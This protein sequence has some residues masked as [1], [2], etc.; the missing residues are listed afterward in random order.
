MVERLDDRT[1]FAVGREYDKSHSS[2]RNLKKENVVALKGVLQGR[3]QVFD[4]MKF[5][6]KCML[7]DQPHYAIL[8]MYTSTFQCG[9]LKCHV[10]DEMSC[11]GIKSGLKERTLANFCCC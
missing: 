7:V 10:E 4:V 3:K 1:C 6:R 5:N 11:G 9:G 8:C 2:L